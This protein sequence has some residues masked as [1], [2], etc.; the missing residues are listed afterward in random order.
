[1]LLIL[2]YITSF[3]G[4]FKQALFSNLPSGPVPGILGEEEGDVTIPDIQFQEGELDELDE[5]FDLE[6]TANESALEY[7]GRPN[8]DMSEM[9]LHKTSDNT[10]GEESQQ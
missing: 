10:A 5:E 7:A 4:D 3:Q 1:M 2:L 8:P 6:M 9:M